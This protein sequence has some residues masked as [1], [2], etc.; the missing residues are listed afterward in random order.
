MAS[1]ILQGTTPVLTIQI[2]EEVSV[3][4][5]IAAELAIRNDEKLTLYHLPELT[6]DDEENTIS[7][8]FTEEETLALNPSSPLNYQLRVKTPSG[9]YG[10]DKKQL[11]VIDLMSEEMI[12]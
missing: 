10:T 3:S 12:E 1:G 7:K 9:I 2:P 4:T 5:I 6:V 8:S 11:R